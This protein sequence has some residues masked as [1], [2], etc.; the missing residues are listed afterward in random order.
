MYVL[1]TTFIGKRDVQV[2]VCTLH[3]VYGKTRCTSTCNFSFFSS[4]SFCVCYEAS[5]NLL[6]NANI[7]PVYSVEKRL[8]LLH[9]ASKNNDVTKCLMTSRHESRQKVYTSKITL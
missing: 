8:T 3:H 7:T 5:Q 1:C 4:P 6:A 2:H 9:L